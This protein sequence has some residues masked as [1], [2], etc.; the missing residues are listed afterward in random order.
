M[1]ARGSWLHP[2]FCKKKAH[3]NQI[4]AAL[5]TV[6][7]IPRRAVL[8]EHY[9]LTSQRVSTIAEI[10]RKL[11]NIKKTLETF[12]NIATGREER[13]EDSSFLFCYLGHVFRTTK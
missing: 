6:L 8:Y 9:L 3:C 13:E 2:V 4:T 11:I 12:G 7:T 5:I 10:Y 1:L